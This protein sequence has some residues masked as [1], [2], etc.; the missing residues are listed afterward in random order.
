MLSPLRSEGARS[1]ETLVA[2]DDAPRTVSH[3]ATRGVAVTIKPQGLRA[4]T[5]FFNNED[6]ITRLVTALA[7][8]RGA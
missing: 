2:A 3:L 7:E 6:D 4:A 1:A 5:H 8:L